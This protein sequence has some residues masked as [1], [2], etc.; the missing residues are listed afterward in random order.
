LPKAAVY[1][2]SVAS[3]GDGL[4]VISAFS[5]RATALAWVPMRAA[6]SACVKQASRRLENR[7][8]HG[9][10]LMLDAFVFRPHFRVGQHFFNQFFMCHHF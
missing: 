9:H 3:E 8:R 6:T 4:P 2:L 1:F 5:R 7:V 10:F